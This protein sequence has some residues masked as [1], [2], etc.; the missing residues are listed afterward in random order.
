MGYRVLSVT[1]EV[2]PDEHSVGR[3]FVPK[4]VRDA[5]GLQQGDDIS[6][7][8]DT[9]SGSYAGIKALGEDG[10]VYGTDLSHYVAAGD[11]IPL[12]GVRLHDLFIDLRTQRGQWLRHARDVRASTACFLSF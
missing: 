10:E 4:Q 1:F 11:G 6:L 8:V 5:L 7:L 3:F 12:P 2:D 9:P